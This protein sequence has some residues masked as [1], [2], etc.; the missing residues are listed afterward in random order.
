[1]LKALGIKLTKLRKNKVKA[2]VDCKNKHNSGV[3]LD[4][5]IKIGNSEICNNMIRDNEVIKEKN[6]QKN[7]KNV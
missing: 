1:M 6:H 3:K 5:N 7:L 4:S 2:S